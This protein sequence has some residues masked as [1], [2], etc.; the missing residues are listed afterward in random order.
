MLP[1]TASGDGYTPDS[2]LAWRGIDTGREA[3]CDLL[4]RRNRGLACVGK[5]FHL[6]ALLR[7]R[8]QA[9]RTG[10]TTRADQIDDGIDEARAEPVEPAL[11]TARGRL[12]DRHR[13]CHA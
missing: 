12:P 4:C 5:R 7:C 10:R 11:A 6:G 13:R 3:G 2:G 1:R 8:L 9:V